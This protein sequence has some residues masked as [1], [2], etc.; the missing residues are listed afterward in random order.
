MRAFLEKNIFSLVETIL[1]MFICILLL[2]D[3]IIKCD[4]DNLM[5]VLMLLV[6]ILAVFISII[7]HLSIVKRDKQIQTLKMLSEIRFSEPDIL[8][9]ED[10]DTETVRQY[11][12][13]LEFLCVGINTGIYDFNILKAM[14][15]R[16]LLCEY[17]LLL[18]EEIKSRRT[19]GSEYIEYEKVI[20]KLVKAYEE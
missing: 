2:F 5:N 17:D 15:G 19:N 12:Q 8:F 20:K 11:L 9:S 4:F 3:K 13:K 6:S 14:S 16:R 1:L 10:I 18:K 7:T